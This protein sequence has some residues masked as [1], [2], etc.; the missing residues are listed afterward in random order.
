MAAAAATF[1]PRGDRD[2]KGA[3]GYDTLLDAVVNGAFVAVRRATPIPSVGTVQS[4]VE[5]VPARA[6]LAGAARLA[7]VDGAAGVLARGGVARLRP[8][9]RLGLAAIRL[10]AATPEDPS[11]MVAM[12]AVKAA[13]ARA[14]AVARAK[15]GGGGGGGCAVVTAGLTDVQRGAIEARD[16][17]L[18]VATHGLGLLQVP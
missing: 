13:R 8:V 4:V 14:R 2:P 18:P 5:V 7:G 6:L 17:L 1:P 15:E 10:A 9:L 12:A 16:A 11:P 3:P